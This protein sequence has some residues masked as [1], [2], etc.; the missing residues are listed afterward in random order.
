MTARRLRYLEYLESCEWWNKRKQVLQRAHYQCERGCGNPA[1]DV[2]HKAGYRELGCERLDDLE[3]L[4][5]VCHA[6]EHEPKNR[7]LPVR[8]LLGQMRLFDRWD[9]PDPPMTR[10]RAA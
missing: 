10:K 3:A 6:Q 8:E 7:A 1:N 2:H 9:D 4:C 5:D